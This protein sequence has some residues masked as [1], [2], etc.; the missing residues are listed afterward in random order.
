MCPPAGR[1]PW[2]FHFLIY[3]TKGWCRKLCR[4]PIAMINPV[5]RV[6]SITQFVTQFNRHYPFQGQA[7]SLDVR[8]VMAFKEQRSPS[9]LPHPN[10]G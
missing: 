9:H 4:K 1:K 3:P 8:G 6:G 2:Q 10:L 7:R 5:L